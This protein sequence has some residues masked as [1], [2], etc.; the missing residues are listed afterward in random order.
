MSLIDLPNFRAVQRDRMSRGRRWLS[1]V[2]GQFWWLAARGYRRTLASRT[3]VVAVIGSLGKTTT[4]HAVV[5]ALGCRAHPQLS[6]NA[7]RNVARALL[8]IRPGERHRVLEVG[9]DGPGQM[10]VY[11]PIVRPDI[12][13]VTC[14][15]SEHQ[16][17]MGSLEHTR[18]EKAE[19]VRILPPAGLAVGNGDDPHVRWMLAQTA[20]RTITFG[21]DEGNDVRATEVLLDA[22]GM[23]FTLTAGPE[24]RT[25]RGQLLGRHQVYAYLAGAAVALH[26]GRTMDQAVTALEALA[27]AAYRMQRVELEGG[28]TLLRDEFKSTVE[29]IDSALDTLEAIPAR[30]RILVLGEVSEPPGS[31]GPVYRR[32]GGRIAGAAD[33]AVHVGHHH[34]RYVAGAA[35][36]GFPRESFLDA[37]TN[38]LNAIEL[39]R[40]KL[41][42]GDVVLVKGRDTQKLQRVSLA[43]MGRTVT[44]PLSR[45]P[46]K[47]WACD[48]C[49]H[50]AGAPPEV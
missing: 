10:A 3:R 7:G 34:Q 13:V 48:T 16:R 31:Q 15:A 45:C 29:T 11:A 42:P 19:M 38:P 27:P 24:R 1:S 20:A 8:R 28:I 17:S 18:D 50:L 14:I 39:L 26:E 6:Y 22:E 41:Q 47:E 44:C 35:R 30:R 2:Y 5:A 43:L 33:L 46:I 25:V 37:G 4:A 49:P 40:G 12:V 32:L 21:L 36:A 23:T 9:V